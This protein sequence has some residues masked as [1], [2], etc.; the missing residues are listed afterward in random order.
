MLKKMG[1]SF[2]D[3]FEIYLSASCFVIMFFAFVIQ[4]FTRYI[5]GYQVRWTYEATVI[6]FMWVVA[7]GASYASRLRDHVSFS[8][9]FDQ[10]SKKAQILTEIIANV[11]IVVTFIIMFRPVLDFISFMK[12]KKTAVLKV[13]LSVLYAPFLYFTVSSV[14]YI[15][16]DSVQSVRQLYELR[17]E[18][19][20][21]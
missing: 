4:I 5:L 17:N 18:R 14:V 1:Q 15:I 21:A 9:V 16:R 20:D 12:I 10:M 3:F 7:F 6:G 19:D 13:P 2:V 11:F 8:L